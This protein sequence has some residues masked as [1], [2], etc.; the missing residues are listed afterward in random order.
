MSENEIKEVIYQLNY[1]INKIRY[2]EMKDMVIHLEYEIFNYL[3]SLN[4]KCYTIKSKDE[5]RVY[6]GIRVE[7]FKGYYEDLYGTRYET[8]FLIKEYEIIN[9]SDLT[10]YIDIIEKLGYKVTGYSV[11]SVLKLISFNISNYYVYIET[12]K[13]IKRILNDVLSTK[14]TQ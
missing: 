10:K 9:Y 7:P 12:F 8:H 2:Y 6:R 11:E 5:M 14:T 13:Q 3:V 4:D 1:A